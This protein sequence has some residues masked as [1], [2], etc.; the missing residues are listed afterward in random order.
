MDGYKLVMD[1]SHHQTFDYDLV[2]QH[3]DGFIIRTAFG[4]ER[5]RCSKSIMTASRK[6]RAPDTSGSGRTRMYLRR[7]KRSN[8][9]AKAKPSAAFSPTRSRLGATTSRCRTSPLPF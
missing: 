8:W 7:S 1:V 6:S 5:I 9:P 4:T 3:V 2:K